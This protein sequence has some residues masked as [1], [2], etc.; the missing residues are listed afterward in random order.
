MDIINNYFIKVYS[1]TILMGSKLD[2]LYKKAQHLK[3]IRII[4]NECLSNGAYSNKNIEVQYDQFRK[5]GVP[6]WEIDIIMKAWDYKKKKSHEL[7]KEL[8]GLIENENR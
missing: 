2:G 1:I 4:T 5:L 7:L 3:K 6:Q 8:E